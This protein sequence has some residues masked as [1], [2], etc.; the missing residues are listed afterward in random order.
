[1]PR[2]GMYLIRSAAGFQLPAKA[3]DDDDMDQVELKAE[4][5]EEERAVPFVVFF[6]EVVDEF[7]IS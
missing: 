6:L 7:F 4:K 5:D 3:K 1:M 2:D